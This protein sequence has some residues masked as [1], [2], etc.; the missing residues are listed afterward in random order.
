[1]DAPVTWY[2]T[3]K[4]AVIGMAESLQKPVSSA[5]VL[6]AEGFKS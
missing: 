5:N 1:M 2:Q 4:Y 3:S 6:D